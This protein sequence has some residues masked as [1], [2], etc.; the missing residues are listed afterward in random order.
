MSACRKAILNAE[1]LEIGDFQ[2][3]NGE[4]G[5]NKLNFD[6]LFKHPLNTKTV[7]SHLGRLAAKYEPDL[8]IGVPRGGQEL[9]ELIIE[10]KCL[11][12]PV[13]KLSKVSSDEGNKWF[14]Y[15]SDLDEELVLGSERI[16]IVEDVF[17][18]FTST[19]GVLTLDLVF[20]RTVAAVACWDRGDPLRDPLDLPHDAL[21][22]EYIPNI[23]DQ[24][25]S[26]YNYGSVVI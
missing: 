16:V 21:V 24:N 23:I 10:N 20:D 4:R 13:A 9:A 18:K 15:S 7:I 1:V 11:E 8:L 22:R 14:E 17:N 26:L 6:N 5:N 25:N 3:A 19:L 12:V 2:Y